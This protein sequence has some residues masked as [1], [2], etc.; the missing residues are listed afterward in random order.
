MFFTVG[1][2][3]ATCFAGESYENGT[4]VAYTAD[5]CDS[6]GH[7]M[8][9]CNATAAEMSEEKVQC[10]LLIPFD[11]C[12]S[13]EADYVGLTHDIRVVPLSDSVNTEL[14]NAS[15]VSDACVNSG[16]LSLMETAEGVRVTM[17]GFSAN[18]SILTL[19]GSNTTVYV[20]NIRVSD[21]TLSTSLLNLTISSIKR[22]S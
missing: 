21:C 18:D 15:G 10:E 13:I 22:L 17:H 12:V 7:A 4:N 3:N 19:T 20:S 6:V 1:F 9:E 2:G 5:V 8:D 14:R 11:K 16:P